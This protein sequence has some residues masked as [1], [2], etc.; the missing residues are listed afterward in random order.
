MAL[1]LLLLSSNAIEKFPDDTEFVIPD[2][3]SASIISQLN[4]VLTNTSDLFAIAYTSPESYLGDSSAFGEGFSSTAVFSFKLSR[5]S[6][7][8]LYRLK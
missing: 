4:Y 8:S 6:F 5:L 3:N 1:K 7:S 2:S